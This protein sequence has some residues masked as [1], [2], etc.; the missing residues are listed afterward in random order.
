VQMAASGEAIA[1]LAARGYD[2]QF[3]ARPVKRV[4]QKEVLN[5]LSKALLG[6]TIDKEQS[7]ILDVFDGK[8]VFRKQLKEEEVVEFMN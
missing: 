2:P 7:V 8:I 3:G 6:N 4:I 1:Y 5:E